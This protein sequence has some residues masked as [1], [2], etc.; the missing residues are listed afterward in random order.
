V[1]SKIFSSGMGMGG[2]IYLRSRMSLYN[3]IFRRGK[4]EVS[5]GVEC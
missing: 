5:L 2:G 4:L 3:A 1:K